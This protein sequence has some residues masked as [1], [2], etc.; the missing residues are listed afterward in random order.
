MA[1]QKSLKC[2]PSNIEALLDAGVSYTNELVREDALNHLQEW[3]KYV[4]YYYY[5]LLFR[6][7]IKYE[8][9]YQKITTRIRNNS[10]YN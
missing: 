7:R 4:N 6:I 2:D 5:Y 10:P 3:L 9:N 1:F 8:K